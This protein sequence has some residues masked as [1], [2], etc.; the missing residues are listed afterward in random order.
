MLT[1]VLRQARRKAAVT[2]F[3]EAGWAIAPGAWWDPRVE[4]YR[5]RRVGCLTTGTIHAA[6]GMAPRSDPSAWAD[7]PATILLITGHGIDVVEL[8][9]GTTPP[10]A[11]FSRA[12]LPGPVALWASVRP[13][14]L[15]FAATTGGGAVPDHL[16]AGLPEGALLHSA[17]SYVPLPPSRVR[18]GDVVWMRPPQSLHWQLPELSEVVDVLARRLATQAPDAAGTP[19]TP[20]TPADQPPPPL[21]PQTA[22]RR[23]ASVRAAARKV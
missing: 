15:V 9:L 5:C 16:P 8:P 7:D 21:A 17:G 4:Q 19:G 2:A 10:E 18:T 20:S 22:Q 12:L 23:R 6:D 13:R 1:G 3:L 11:I 14:L